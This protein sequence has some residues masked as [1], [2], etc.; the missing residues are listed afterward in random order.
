MKV[1]G[2]WRCWYS[3]HLKHYTRVDH[4]LE[5]HPIRG[6]TKLKNVYDTLTVYINWRR[7]VVYSQKHS[8]ILILLKDTHTKHAIW[9]NNI[10]SLQVRGPNQHYTYDMHVYKLVLWRHPILDLLKY[11]KKFS[12]H[13]K[14]LRWKECVEW[15]LEGTC[16]WLVWLC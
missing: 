14:Y 9:Y 5:I 8:I 12:A 13:R 4:A 1:G 7:L 11:H 6:T 3:V 2:W 10:P 16:L 15:M